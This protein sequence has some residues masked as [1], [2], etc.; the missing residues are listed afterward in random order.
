MKNYTDRD[1]MFTQAVFLH[2]TVVFC[3]SFVCT[4]VYSCYVFETIVFI[5]IS[6][7]FIYY[8]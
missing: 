3:C 1:R 5:Y 6:I 2:S 8:L 7:L 4:L